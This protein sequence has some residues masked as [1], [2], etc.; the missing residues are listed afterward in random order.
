LSNIYIFNFVGLSKLFYSKVASIVC[1]FEIEVVVG[2]ACG[3]QEIST[4][5]DVQ[6][7]KDIETDD[8]CHYT[9]TTFVVDDYDDDDD[10]KCS[11]KQFCYVMV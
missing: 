6:T 7:M 8:Q 10:D 5:L 2:Y 4:F 11:S 1:F 3:V 9:N